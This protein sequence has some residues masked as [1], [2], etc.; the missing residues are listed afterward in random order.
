MAAFMGD[1]W[2]LPQ[3]GVLS[4][5]VSEDWVPPVTKALFRTATWLFPTGPSSP[6]SLSQGL[7][8]RRLVWGREVYHAEGDG[9]R[10]SGD[11]PSEGR[12]FVI[13][14]ES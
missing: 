3:L 1:T 7:L 13:C 14:W 4:L 2:R 12:S 6:V 9:V 11:T 10:P 8:P 5:S